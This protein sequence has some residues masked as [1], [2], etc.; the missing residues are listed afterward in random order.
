MNA[1]RRT[2][3][4]T[5][6]GAVAQNL[7]ARSCR[8]GAIGVVGDVVE[9]FSSGCYV[10]FGDELVAVGNV[11]RGPLHVVVDGAQRDLGSGRSV[12]LRA[13]GPPAT[14]AETAIANALVIDLSR[15]RLW[16]PSPPRGDELAAL[17]AS[18]SSLDVDALVASDLADVWDSACASIRA[19]DAQ[20]AVEQ[21]QGRGAGLTPTGDDVIAGLLLAD[22]W[23]R[24]DRIAEERRIEL[25]GAVRTTSLSLSFLRWAA[26][27]QSIE[28][29]HR[30][31]V[32]AASRD[33]ER[34]AAA[35]EAVAAIGGSSGRALLAGLAAGLT[36]VL[37]F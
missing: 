11:P 23:T 21:L 3:C 12:M 13:G 15:A 16:A 9:R 22:A 34:F 36:D 26:V 37:A 30:L 19:G 18:C 1:T 7:V 20:R 5:S 14:I 17:S 31:V 27:G 35:T 2:V 28:P 24:P 4:A 33:P 6:F 8:D 25:A 10:R 29:V 32:A